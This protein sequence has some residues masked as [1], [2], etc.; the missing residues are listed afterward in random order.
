M[1]RTVWISAEAVVPACPSLHKGGQQDEKPDQWHCRNGEPTA[2]EVHIV[3]PSGRHGDRWE[4]K[5]DTV[6]GA[7]NSVVR[8]EEEPE[9][10]VNCEESQHDDAVDQNVCPVL[11]SRG[12]ALESVVIPHDVQVVPDKEQVV[13]LPTMLVPNRMIL[14]TALAHRSEVLYPTA[15]VQGWMLSSSSANSSRATSVS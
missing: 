3:Q 12:S 1:A 7:Q 9:G 13:L 14:Q 6:G 2:A 15:F 5:C 11:P 8:T 4:S 10:R